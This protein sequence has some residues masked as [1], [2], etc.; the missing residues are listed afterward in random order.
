MVFVTEV[1]HGSNLLISGVK[2]PCTDALHA[3]L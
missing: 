1:L 2:G 3:H